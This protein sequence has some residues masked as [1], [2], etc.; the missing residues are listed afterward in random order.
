MPYPLSSAVTPGD[1]TEADQYNN[2]RADAI[3]LGDATRGTVRDLLINGIPRCMIYGTNALRLEGPCALL[4]GGAIHTIT[5]SI[6]L[7]ASGTLYPEETVLYLNAHAQEDGSFTLVY[8]TSDTS[9]TGET[10]LARAIWTGSAFIPGSLTTLYNKDP[11]PADP[12]RCDGRLTLIPGTPFPESDVTGASKI[13]F[14]PC[15]GNRIALYNGIWHEYELEQLVYH[16]NSDSPNNCYDLFVYADGS[17][18]HLEA[19]SWGTTGPRPAGSI[20]LKDGVRVKPGEP[21]RRY[22]GTYAPT[23]S[24][25]TADSVTK[26]MLWNQYHRIPRKL[27]SL[28]PT[29]STTYTLTANAWQPYYGDNAPEV[30]TVIGCADGDLE[31]EGVGQ[32]T[33]RTDTDSTYDRTVFLGI[34]KDMAKESPYTGNTSE[35]ALN[36]NSYGND[37]LRVHKHAITPSDTGAH[38]WTLSVYTNYSQFSLFPANNTYAAAANQRPGLSGKVTG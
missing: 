32:T 5:E 11:K 38:T 24:G 25:A 4:I 28:L 33:Y 23:T 14:E 15:G 10:A 21:S 12:S 22:V 37:P 27:E 17:G 36:T 34:S 30:Q 18:L 2:L 13:Y 9:V 3:Y 1:P 6:T 35:N 26:R 29:L 7:P 8:S 31:L 20:A 19:E 16:T